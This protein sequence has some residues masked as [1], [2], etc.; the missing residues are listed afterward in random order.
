MDRKRN[1]KRSNVMK[2]SSRETLK[3]L[4]Q[5]KKQ[6]EAELVQI[7]NDV[8]SSVDSIKERFLSSLL[9]VKMI[10]KKPFK[11]VGIAVLAGFTLGLPRLRLGKRRKGT[12]G[13]RDSQ[14]VTS[15]MMDELKRIA[16]RRAVGLFVDTLD[17]QLA[18]LNEQD[19][20]HKRQPVKNDVREQ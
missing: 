14:G 2:K 10:H 13:R 17:D 5:R 15:L 9:P 18:K 20:E 6:I 12:A 1:L 3:V 19:T 7:Q 16:A 4:E 8:D 11:A